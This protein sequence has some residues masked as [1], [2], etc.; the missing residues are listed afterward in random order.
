LHRHA[1]AQH[2]LVAPTS[3]NQ[4][5]DSSLTE[6]HST[7]RATRASLRGVPVHVDCGRR[8]RWRHCLDRLPDLRLFDRALR[9]ARTRPSAPH[10]DRRL[11][12]DT[13]AHISMTAPLAVDVIIPTSA[14]QQRRRLLHHAIYSVVTQENVRPRVILVTNGPRTQEPAYIN[15]FLSEYRDL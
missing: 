3:Q 1:G 9:S 7:G 5:R 4:E 6:G 2:S 8:A 14:D 11:A 12:L 13:G 15:D 10:V